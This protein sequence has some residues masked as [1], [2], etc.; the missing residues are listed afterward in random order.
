MPEGTHR[1]A[2]FLLN[3]PVGGCVWWCNTPIGSASANM[4]FFI[5]LYIYREIVVRRPHEFKIACLQDIR[6]L[7]PPD[8][9]PFYGGFGNRDTDE[10]SYKMVGVPVSRTFTINPK[11]QI[12]KA[13]TAL[14]S[15]TWSSLSA[16]NDLVDEIFPPL[17]AAALR[18]SG[19][20]LRQ[21]QSSISSSFG[22]SDWE[23]AA[24]G[25]VGDDVLEAAIA[26]QQRRRSSG[27][28]G[29]VIV[30]PTEQ[31]AGVD[32]AESGSAAAAANDSSKAAAATT[33]IV[34][35]GTTA[36]AAA[37][38]AAVMYEAGD[39][40]SIGRSDQQAA[41]PELEIED[42]GPAR[43][44]FSDLQYWKTSVTFSIDIEEE[45]KQVEKTQQQKQQQQQ[46]QQQQTKK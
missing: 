42:V 33:N 46:V 3:C 38:N 41:V 40:S 18:N 22:R 44:E 39:N 9:N 2:W 6:A 10:V 15:S 23:L 17:P 35:D 45:L 30:G 8:W 25:I 36:A 28:G 19:R 34:A 21:Q 29:P 26:E 7:F 16:I 32:S 24:K 43:E 4:L 1:P 13:S 31:K 14:Q 12:Q 37:G 20:A 27:T 11:G 5:S